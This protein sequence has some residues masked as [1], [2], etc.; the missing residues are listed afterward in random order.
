M[1]FT[2]PP[3]NVPVHGH[4]SGKGKAKHREF[5]MASGE[6]SDEAFEGF[7]VSD[8]STRRTDLGF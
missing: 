2:D 8:V 6:M 3:Y 1:V 7:L 5:I 4:V